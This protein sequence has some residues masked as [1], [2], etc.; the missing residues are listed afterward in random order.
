MPNAKSVPQAGVQAG[1]VLLRVDVRGLQMVQQLRVAVHTPYSR[2][3][4]DR[5]KPL[6]PKL[7]CGAVP[8]GAGKR[9]VFGCERMGLL[10]QVASGASGFASAISVSMLGGDRWEEDCSDSEQLGDAFAWRASSWEDD[11]GSCCCV[12]SRSIVSDLS[13]LSLEL[14][15]MPLSLLLPQSTVSGLSAGGE[16]GA[17]GGTTIADVCVDP[18]LRAGSAPERTSLGSGAAA[19]DETTGGCFESCT[20]TRPGGSPPRDSFCAPEEAVAPDDTDEETPFS[21]A[22]MIAGSGGCSGCSAGML[23]VAW[24]KAALSCELIIAGMAA[25]FTNIPPVGVMNS[26]CG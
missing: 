23:A 8:D 13:S 14:A 12:V 24:V 4:P 20:G 21:T 19:A 3:S 22:F 26:C 18:L 11:F 2:P 9:I 5:R 16:V 1:S 17:A 7:W 10:A 15:T 6:R 25:A